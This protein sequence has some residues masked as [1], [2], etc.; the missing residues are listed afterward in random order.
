VPV[1]PLLM[2]MLVVLG[3]CT[4]RSPCCSQHSLHH[5]DAAQH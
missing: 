4:R 5:A 1:L 3:P 2:L